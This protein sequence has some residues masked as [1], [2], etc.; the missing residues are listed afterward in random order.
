MAKAHGG[1]MEL[2]A[3]MHDYLFY[4]LYSLDLGQAREVLD[5]LNTHDDQLT[6]L[7]MLRDAIVA[8]A[9][10]FSGNRLDPTKRHRL[11]KHVVR[12]E[13]RPLHKELMTLRNQAFA[14]T[15]YEF[16]DPS[17]SRLLGYISGRAA[18][19][20]TS[21]AVPW[22]TL[23]ERLPEIRGLVA[24][25]ELSVEGWIEVFDRLYGESYK[26]WMETRAPV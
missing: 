9:R 4:R 8:Y 22:T 12:I 18:Y 25:V 16:R 24:Q 3:T 21:R 26:P 15:D 20:I 17:V 14:H 1:R 11:P 23:L 2:P 19:P 5:A 10:P 6:R 13:Y 7:S